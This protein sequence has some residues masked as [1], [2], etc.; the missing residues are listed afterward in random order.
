[1]TVRT[2]D[3]TLNE[4]ELYRVYIALHLKIASLQKPGTPLILRNTA[5]R[6]EAVFAK[7]CAAYSAFYGGS[8]ATPSSTKSLAR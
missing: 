3:L 7:V 5:E 1:M 4:D 2:A 8:P 6:Y